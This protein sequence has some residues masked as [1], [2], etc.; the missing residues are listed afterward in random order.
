L[1]FA[2]PQQAS[3]GPIGTGQGV[4]HVHLAARQPGPC[5]SQIS[6]RGSEFRIL[7]KVRK[8]LSTEKKNEQWITKC[9]LRNIFLDFFRNWEYDCFVVFAN[10]KDSLLPL[11]GDTKMRTLTP[12][13]ERVFLSKL[14]PNYNIEKDAPFDSLRQHQTFKD[15]RWTRNTV[16]ALLMLDAGLRVDECC[17][18]CIDDL[19]YNQIPMATLTVRAAVSKTKTLRRVPLS[20]RLQTMLTM[21]TCNLIYRNTST[22]TAKL[23]SATP[24]GSG[25]SARA[26]QYAFEAASRPH[27]G[28]RVHPHCLRHTFAT[29]L[30]AVT[31]IRTVQEMLGHAALSSTQIYTHVS[32]NDKVTA[33]AALESTK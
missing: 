12:L 33:I 4:L 7:Y 28:W 26:I 8:K 20:R 29:K 1:E 30:L 22:P 23:L 31:N 24:N 14:N 19:Y 32:E 10:A 15:W 17:K 11:F 5:K 9:L 2:A 27:L 16:A 6:R 21:Y 13:E 3:H 18:L 25:L